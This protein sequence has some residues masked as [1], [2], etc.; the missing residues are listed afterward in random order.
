MT[1]EE[2]ATA[3][4]TTA[5]HIAAV[6]A[7]GLGPDG[8]PL[9]TPYVADVVNQA[10]QLSEGQD[11]QMSETADGNAFVV[12][13]VDGITAPA[14][15]PLDTVKNDVAMAW[16]AQK[17]AEMA[18]EL[19]K[20]AQARLQAGEDA[21]AVAQSIGFAATVTTPFT[22]DGKGLELDALPANLIDTLFTLKTGEATSAEGT[23]AHTVA[24][25]AT[26]VPATPDTGS[27]IYRA[28]ADKALTDMQGDLLSQLSSALEGTY[29]VTINQK[30][31]N[32]AY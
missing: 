24:R 8:K 17:R 3:L 29:G 25:L 7:Q 21:A 1:F 28:V 5:T 26:I 18:A 20:A 9:T 19:A 12:V 4:G 27:A 15:R 6:D 14:L 22:R 11:G 13:R 10:F 16:D 2:A 32:D 23:G 31:L 30:A